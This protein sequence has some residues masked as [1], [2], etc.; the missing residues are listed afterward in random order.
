M[1]KGNVVRILWVIAKA[2]ERVDGRLTS[3]MASIRYRT[4]IPAESLAGKEFDSDFLTVSQKDSY[5]PADF[6]LRQPPDVVV[7]SKSYN[8]TTQQVATW[9]HRMGARIVVDMCDNRLGDAGISPDDP[10][11]AR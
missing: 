3:A 9:A 11:I 10:A 8:D 6:D 1:E 4:L 2:I 7:I 5:D